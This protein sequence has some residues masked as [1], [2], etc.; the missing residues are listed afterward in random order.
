MQLKVEVDGFDAV[1]RAFDEVPK[2]AR[3]ASSIA[4]NRTLEEALEAGRQEIKGTM[5]VRV[6][7]FILPPTQLPNHARA[8]PTK[9]EGVASFG[10]ADVFPSSIGAR[11]ETIL[12]K[13]EYGGTKDAPD[14]QF[15]IALPTKALR[16][17]PSV[18]V[19]RAMYPVNLRLVPRR[20]ADNQELGALRRGKVRTLSG[21]NVRSKKHRGE[22]Q[23]EGIG[24]TFGVMDESGRLQWVFQRT[25][26]GSRDIRLIWAF[27]Q[28]IR[29][30]KL[31]HFTDLA[32]RIIDD[33]FLVN[34]NGAWAL[35]L[36]TAK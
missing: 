9:L 25:G 8:K 10:Y 22:L 21:G 19:P 36:G 18:V 20:T 2:Q 12:R 24:G 4:I 30:P 6:P 34:F 27:R 33:R 29:I 16:P 32:G 17:S 5:T 3:F 26:R 35:A 11:R 31:L 7:D 23:L 13:F 1:Q 28:S 14:P 15:P